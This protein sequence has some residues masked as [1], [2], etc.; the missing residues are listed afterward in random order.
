MRIAI[1]DEFRK[2][3]EDIIKENK[4]QDE[5]AM[6]ESDDMFQAKSYCGGYDADEAAFCFSYYDDNNIEYWLQVNLEE[7]K[8]I[9]NKEVNT[10]D[11]RPAE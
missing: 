11:I 7:V 1:T 9:A 2:I 3:C 6:I 5:W 4:S 8:K 10:L